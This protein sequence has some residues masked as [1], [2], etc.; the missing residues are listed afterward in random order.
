MDEGDEMVV[1][2]WTNG[3]RKDIDR[4]FGSSNLIDD[5]LIIMMQSRIK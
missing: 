4:N 1:F 2:N 5:K 3:F